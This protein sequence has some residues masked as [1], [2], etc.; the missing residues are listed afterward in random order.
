MHSDQASLSLWCVVRIDDFPFELRHPADGHVEPAMS[1]DIQH[2]EIGMGTKKALAVLN[3]LRV[4][5][6][7]PIGLHEMVV[8]NKPPWSRHRRRPV[9]QEIVA[10][11]IM[12][13]A[14]KF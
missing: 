5:A 7:I 9:Q 2:Q 10:C 11:R 1:S 14:H 12:G 4:V 8:E 3:I 6:I 13:E